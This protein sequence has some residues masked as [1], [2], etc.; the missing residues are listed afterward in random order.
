MQ[1]GRVWERIMGTS[2]EVGQDARR[3]CHGHGSVLHQQDT[4]LCS[5]GSVHA[6]FC[7]LGGVVFG[8]IIMTLCEIVSWMIKPLQLRLIARGPAYMAARGRVQGFISYG[9]M[10]V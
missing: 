10:W 3:R 7:D 1:S 6:L 4:Q 9:G 5:R 8:S 2:D